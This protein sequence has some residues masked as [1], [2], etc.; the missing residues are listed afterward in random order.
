M[1]E[2]ASGGTCMTPNS[3]M[4]NGLVMYDGNT[5]DPN[6]ITG[7]LAQSWELSADGLAYIFRLRQN[8]R[9]HDGKP[10]TGEDVVF[11]LNQMVRTDV[12]RPR[13]GQIRPYYESS[14]VIDPLTVQVKLKFPAAAF[15]PFM[16]TEFMKIH[17]KHHVEPGLAKDPAFL[18]KVDNVLG[19]GPF[20]LKNYSKDVSI[21]YE[22]NPNYFKEGLPY[23]DGMT[24]YLME[25]SSTIL[26][27]YKAQQ[28]LTSSFINSNLSI[29]EG[30]QL[31]K[32]MEG[33]G[34]VYF[35]G[36][37]A[38]VGLL[39]NTKVEPFTDVRVRRAL[40]LTLHRQPFLETFG[41]GK[42]PLGGPFPPGSWFSPTEEELAK[43]PGLRQTPDGQK[44]PEDIAAAKKLLA[45]A[46]F[47]NG[48][49]T[50]IMAAQFIGFPD[51]AQ[52]AADQLK[53]FVNIEATVQP[54]ETAAGYARYEAGDWKLGFHGDG[55][56]ILDPDAVIQGSYL[57]GGSRNYSRWE[58]D[59]VTEFNR[60]QTGEADREKRRQT[61]LQMGN[62]LM[63][64]DTH[65]VIT[66]WTMLATYVDNRIKN[67]HLPTV[68]P[69]HA[70]QEHLWFEKK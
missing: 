46:G 66:H 26:A 1:W 36:P 31:A 59:R 54:V 32:D 4:Y 47:P 11:S 34:T 13:A 9:W 29:R 58:P 62:Y 69:A 48:F 56:L 22:R 63:N 14:R 55:F 49:K 6:D 35:P 17:P 12:S 57:K 33:K 37:I 18:K 20:K 64:E 38:W 44:H 41:A 16:A 5:P 50:T 15:L 25:T 43:L 23:F 27:A 40:Q 19:S 67:Y 60:L 53:R 52:V 45:D 24:Y 3:P 2:C 51:M 61:V 7:D 28:V 70:M 21:E 68:F 10:V 42:Y 65:V 8:A 30:I 39:I